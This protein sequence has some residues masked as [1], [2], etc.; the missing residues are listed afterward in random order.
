MEST[1]VSP[2]AVSGFESFSAIN[3]K[4][5]SLGRVTAETMMGMELISHS[6][7]HGTSGTF[8]FKGV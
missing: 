4:M 5:R 8:E 3:T 7:S 6:E 2:K 1:V